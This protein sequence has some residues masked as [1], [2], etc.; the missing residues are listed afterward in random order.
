VRAAG[1]AVAP[2][3]P[4]ALADAAPV[5][6]ASG[7][8]QDLETLGREL[9]LKD[10][11]TFAPGPGELGPVAR[12]ANRHATASIALHGA[13]VTAFQPRGQQPVLWVSAKSAFRPAKA[14]RG[15][16]PICWPWFADHPTDP[17]K[18]AHGFV[19]TARWT[20]AGTEAAADGATRIRLALADDETTRALWPHRF[21][22]ELAVTVG[23]SL[24]VTLAIRNTGDAAFTSGGAL[25]SYFTVGD[26]TQV[27]IRGL[28]GRTYVDKV[29]RL[30]RKVQH[31]VVRIAGETDRVY[32]DTTAECV[33]DDPVLRRRIT[34]AK[35]GSR[36]TVVWNPWRAKAA[37]MADFGDD[38]YP[39]MVCVETANAG[40]D[41]V[42]VPAGGR[43]VLRTTIGV[44]PS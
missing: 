25:H 32:L 1:T 12:V 23:R 19:R 8:M 20:V 27:A 14:I 18:P 9:A 29:D 4:L 44:E 30:A 6:V 28:D 7:D 36:S 34:V 21:E 39:G 41:V 16:I 2:H 3:D 15:G 17:T 37:S 24:D 33:I 13:H 5:V 40:D 43:H 42:A 38:E 31:G 26:V 10:H 22:L 35:A 11:V